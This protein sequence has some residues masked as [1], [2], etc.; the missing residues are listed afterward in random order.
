[1]NYIE[2]LRDVM[3]KMIASGRP[4]EEVLKA[5]DAV[6]YHTSGSA[7]PSTLK[8]WEKIWRARA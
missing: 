5:G 7:K 2:T 8:R 3:K 4:V 6:E 1:M